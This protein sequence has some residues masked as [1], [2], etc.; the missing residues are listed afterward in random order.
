MPLPD[1]QPLDYAIKWISSTPIPIW[2][3][4]RLNRFPRLPI[5]DIYKWLYLVLKAS[6][7]PVDRVWR[8]TNGAYPFAF[9]L[10]EDERVF[11]AFVVNLKVPAPLIFNA[12]D[13]PIRES[14]RGS[15]IPIEITVR[16]YMRLMAWPYT[17]LSF[18]GWGREH[19]ECCKRGK[20]TR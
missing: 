9:P 13:T 1:C 5:L 14:I 6:Q 12:G 17:F 2:E 19:K 18:R 3:S 8:T 11:S 4:I 10:L 20:H 16:Q 15:G 7:T